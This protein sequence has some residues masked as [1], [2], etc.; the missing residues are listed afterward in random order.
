MIGMSSDERNDGWGA[1]LAGPAG[2]N[3]T[4]TRDWR[5]GSGVT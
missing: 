2:E 3:D 1:E 4:C 5:L